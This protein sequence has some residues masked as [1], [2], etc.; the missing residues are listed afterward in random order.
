MYN[1][2]HAHSLFTGKVEETFLLLPLFKL[3]ETL[4]YNTF[5]KFFSKEQNGKRK[6]KEEE[7]NG[8]AFFHFISFPKKL[9]TTL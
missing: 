7:E 8:K 5:E 6:T 2:L 1:P 4:F 9:F 3:S